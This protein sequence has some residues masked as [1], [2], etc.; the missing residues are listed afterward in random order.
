VAGIPEVDRQRHAE[1]GYSGLRIETGG[2]RS[3]REAG[4]SKGIK[5]RFL[6]RSV[7]RTSSTGSELIVACQVVPLLG[8]G[9]RDHELEE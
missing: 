6:L 3:D 4:E 8:H 1:M 7:F 2:T 9:V 5:S